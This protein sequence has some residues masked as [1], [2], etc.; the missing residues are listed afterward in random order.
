MKE[1]L[2]ELLTS[3]GQEHLLAFWDDLDDSQEKSLAAEI[4]NVDFDGI[5]RAFAEKDK[6]VE[7]LASIERAVDPPA[8]R[9]DCANNRFSPNW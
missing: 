3:S 2:V 4:R 6:R 1:D 8:F 9:L 5:S 7:V